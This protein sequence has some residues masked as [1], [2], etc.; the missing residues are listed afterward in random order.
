MLR[1]RRTVE[2]RRSPLDRGGPLIAHFGYRNM[3]VSWMQRVLLAVGKELGLRTQISHS[4]H[5]QLDYRTQLIV[6]GHSHL[7]PNK[8]RE[9]VGSHLV[10]DLRDVV[11]NGYFKHRQSQEAWT[12]KPMARYGGRTYHQVLSSLDEHDGLLEEIRQLASY[13][14]LYNMRLWDYGEADFAELRYEDLLKREGRFFHKLFTH[15]GFDKTAIKTAVAIARRIGRVIRTGPN[16][17]TAWELQTG[18]WRSRFMPEHKRLLKELLGD[19]LIKMGY[20]RDVNW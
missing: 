1:F 5:E 13:C 9:F 18:I 17:T 7:R 15:Y 19:L 10:R 11:V 6:V 2:H 8:F 12:H 16:Q 3:G 14:K 20:E 4:F